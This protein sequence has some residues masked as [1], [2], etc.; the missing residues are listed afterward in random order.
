MRN[1]FHSAKHL[2]LAAGIGF[3]ADAGWG[4]A[5]GSQIEGGSSSCS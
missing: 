5:I 4:V 3:G 1:M 2:F